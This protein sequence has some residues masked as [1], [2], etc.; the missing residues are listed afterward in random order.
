MLD[1]EP[2]GHRTYV[3]RSNYPL[4]RIILSSVIKIR[5]YNSG[6]QQVWD[7]NNGGTIE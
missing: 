1:F 2:V 6:S 4:V 7:Q 5:G 3:A